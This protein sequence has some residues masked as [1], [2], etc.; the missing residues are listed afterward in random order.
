MAL[1]T[2][3]N[4][5]LGSGIDTLYE[6]INLVIEPKQR[7]CLIGRNGT[8][9]ST[10]F[11]ML[12][13][14]VAPDKGTIERQQDL[15]IAQLVQDIPT[16][17]QGTIYETVARGFGETGALLIQYERILQATEHSDNL[18]I[19][20]EL[21]TLQEQL[22]QQ[23]GWQLDQKIKSILSKMNLDPTLNMQSLSGGMIRR[24]LMATALVV[25]PDILMLD[26]PTNHLDIETIIWLENFLKQYQKTIIFITH[27]K[28][29]L[30]NLAT[31]IIEL[32][33]G[34]LFSWTG[35][36]ASFLRFKEEQL[37]AEAR[38]N[39]LFDKRLAEEERWIRQGIKARRTRN[40]GR[41]RVLEKMRVERQA[42]RNRPDQL[43]LHHQEMQASGKLVFDVENLHYE[44][45][46][47]VIIDDLSALITRGD[48]VG[49][50]GP[51]GCGKST[52]LRLL[53][54]NLQPTSGKVKQGTQLTIS[55][56]D[57]RREQLDENK[58]VQ[59]NIYDGGD[60]ITLNGKTIHIMRYLNDFLFTPQRARTPTRSLSGGER[61]RLVL[62]RL[63]TKPSNILVLD[64][65]TNDLDVETLDL[66]QEY[67][68]DYTGTI[69]L[70]SHDRD[71]LDRVVTSTI[72]FE[73]DGKVVEYNGGYTD[74]MQTKAASVSTKKIVSADKKDEKLTTGLVNEKKKLSYKEKTELETL[75]SKIEKLEKEQ[76][77][78]Q[79][80]MLASDFFKQDKVN[81]ANHNQRLEQVEKEL[82]LAYQR[83]SELDG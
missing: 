12:K 41:V 76:T 56:F 60:F 37:S 19:F 72:V 9:K 40:E 67:L 25:E 17:L 26:E 81:I 48:K 32:D 45:D 55:Y 52:L 42:R 27:D 62:A 6:N 79:E 54:G 70:V 53:L 11:K 10:L 28:R 34:K 78:L 5:Y 16:H 30:Q 83:W 80:A 73:G 51:N 82:Q 66:L 47:K 1:I 24:V 59:E 68:I 75:P 61:N 50:V 38:A 7:I 14:E 35:D 65:P 49:I 77:T 44:I 18:E 20:E 13:G 4:I 21:H 2:L 3:R 58:T 71:F 33:N 46:G 64:E 15:S 63:F 36:Y 74:Y 29:F 57:Q 43:R 31:H 39:D 23:Q 8:G 22:E 69:L